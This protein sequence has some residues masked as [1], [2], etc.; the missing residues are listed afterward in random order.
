MP[1][2]SSHSSETNY[3]QF[4]LIRSTWFIIFS[5]QCSQDTVHGLPIS[6]P[7]WGLVIKIQISGSHP[8]PTESESLGIR[9]R[10]LLL[11]YNQ[12]P[13]DSYPH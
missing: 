2:R 4:T 5:K 10:N 11:Y 8:R 3:K 9:L 12:P 13:K 1:S 6:E 7:P